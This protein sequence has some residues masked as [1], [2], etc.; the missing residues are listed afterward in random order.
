MSLT[1]VRRMLIP[2]FLVAI[3]YSLKYRC[4]ISPRAEV[5]LSDRL[6]IGR[7]TEISSFAKIKAMRGAVRIGRRVS[8]GTG[9]FISTGA[10]GITIGDSC[11]IGANASIIANNH[12]YDN[13]KQPMRDQGH[14]SLGIVMAED[15]WVGTGAVI[16]DGARIERGV[17][18]TPNSVVSGAVPAFAVVQGHPAKSIFVRR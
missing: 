14:T 12:R 11:M 15:V 13:V 2:R 10:E 5:D 6:T 4:R 16:L 1:L 18:V 9:C 17:I 7:G 3:Y 8:I